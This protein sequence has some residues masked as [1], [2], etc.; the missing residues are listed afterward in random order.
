M[1]L[2]LLGWDIIC[3]PKSEGGLGFKKAEFNNLAMLAR[4]AWMII[5]NP[6]CLLATVLKSRYFPRTDFL[7]A[8]CPSNCSWTWKLNTHFD[9]ASVE[10]I[11]TIPLSHICTPDM[12]AWELSKNGRFTYK[13]AYLGLRGLRPSQCSAFWKRIWKIRVPYKI[14]VFTWK[15]TMNALPARIILNTRMHMLSV[16]CTR[17][18]DPHE[19]ILHALVL[20]PFASRVWF[21]SSFCVNTQAFSNKS[22]IDWMMFWLVDLVSELPDGDQ[23]FFVAILWSIWQSRKNPIFQNVKE[24]DSAVLMS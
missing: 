10:K 4:N 14:Q 16:D 11:I 15:A 22:F 2:H 20:R 19:S 18:N 5:E 1:K 17:C 7:N 12:R 24:N 13:S 6:N 3:S 21:L 23:C 8:K 9:D